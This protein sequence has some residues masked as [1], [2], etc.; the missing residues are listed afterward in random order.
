MMSLL[1]QALLFTTCAN[2]GYCMFIVANEKF[3]KVFVRTFKKSNDSGQHTAK[4]GCRLENYRATSLRL[5]SHRQEYESGT[6]RVPVYEFGQTRVCVYF[7][8][9]RSHTHEYGLPV[10]F[11]RSSSF[12]AGRVSIQP[13]R[14]KLPVNNNNIMYESCG[15]YLM[16]ELTSL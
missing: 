14:S 6:V 15:A 2:L 5:R 3:I 10:N 13:M 11:T 8:G 7:N 1:A 12:F 16:S 4:F 9:G